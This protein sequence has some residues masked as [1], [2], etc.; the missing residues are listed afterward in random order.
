M[1]PQRLQ[2][3]RCRLARALAAGFAEEPGSSQLPLSPT[4]RVRDIARGDV[5]GRNPTAL[6][7]WCQL[8]CQTHYAGPCCTRAGAE[9]SHTWALIHAGHVRPAHC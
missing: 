9:T 7:L 4:A 8:S 1:L 2:R 5:W 3:A 6:S